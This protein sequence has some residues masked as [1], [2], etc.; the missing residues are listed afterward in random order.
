MLLSWSTQLFATLAAQVH[1]AAL[2]QNIQRNTFNPQLLRSS[3]S[4]RELVTEL[5]IALRTT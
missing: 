5:K 3:H 4:K 1:T 2:V